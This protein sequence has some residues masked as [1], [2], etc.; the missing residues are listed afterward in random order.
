MAPL[1]LIQNIGLT[2]ADTSGQTATVGE[3]TLANND[4]EILL[5]GNWYATKSLDGGGS[6][7]SLDPFTL[8]PSAAGGFCCDQ[9]IVFE[10]NHNLFFWLLQYVR[11]DQGTNILRLAVKQGGTLGDD[12]WYW[13][14]FSPAG[15]NAEW[16][17]EWFDYPDLELGDNFLYMTTNSFSGDSFRRSVVFRLPL[18]SLAQPGTLNFQYFQSPLF[19]LRCVRGAGTTM[20]F[21]CHN[22]LSQVRIFSWPEAA[23]GITFNDV[24]VTP[25]NAGTYSA[26]GPDGADWLTRCDP[27]IT[28][29][30]L[31]N[32]NIGLAWSVNS[33]GP[34]PFPHVRVVEISEAQMQVVADRDIWSDKF[35][36][37][38]PNGAA[39]EDGVVGITLFMG[40]GDFNPSHVVGS[41]DSGSNAWSLG[42]TQAGSNGPND[43]KWG[44]Y[45]TCRRSV[46]DGRNWFASGYT[47]EG[48]GARTNIEPRVVHFSQ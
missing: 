20:Y 38:Y 25:W 41:F 14:D 22:S 24:N 30:W 21:A 29:A 2:D 28:G 9:V 47:L 1:T 15:T 10:P 42:V 33:R 34:R 37:A 5:A 35:A 32:G 23:G 6:W 46:S 36:Y 40:G 12:N 19:S 45:L 31:A 18:E 43:G 26:P 17:D 48:G 3:P 16:S 13:W 27:R 7:Q 39:N 8:F 44:D 11:D 4:K